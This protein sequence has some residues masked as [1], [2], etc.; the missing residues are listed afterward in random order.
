MKNRILYYILICILL[1]TSGS[2]TNNFEEINTNP[3]TSAKALPENMLAPA[4][5]AVVTRNMYVAKDIGQEL[6]QVTVNTMTEVDRIHRYDIRLSTVEAPWRIWYVQLTNFKEIYEFAEETANPGYKGI[7]LICQAWVHSLITDTYGDAPYFEA[8]QAKEGNFMPRFDRQRDIYLDLFQKLEEAN[9]ILRSSANISPNSDPVYGGNIAKW[10]K[11]GNSLYLRLLLRAS[12]NPEVATDVIAK[13]KQIAETHSSDY[14]IFVNNSESAILR[15]TGNPPY[16][17]PFATLTNAEWGRP[18]ASS[19]FVDHLDQS[20]D[21]NISR[22]VTIVDGIY[23]GIPSGYSIGDTPEAISLMQGALRSDPL[24]GNIMNFA[25]VQ[26]ILAEAALKGW[27]STG[28]SPQ[29]YYENGVT[30]RITLWGRSVGTFLSGPMVVWDD[31]NLTPEQ[32]LERIIHQ[33][34][35]ALFYTDIQSWSEYRRTGYPVLPKGPALM[36]DRKMPT[37]LVYPLTVQAANRENYDEV[38]AIQGPDNLQTQL[39]WQKR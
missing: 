8:N 24:L 26:F 14:P 30:A 11:F 15:W 9:R 2:C 13:I 1:L 6:M 37:R 39:W 35:Y 17:S 38:V 28:S 19:F 20:M 27:I 18:K 16:A 4:L 12:G 25:E 34:Y 10:R 22:W 5:A 36:N 7:S 23:G 31:E 21:P 32:K 3:N 33:K 29:N